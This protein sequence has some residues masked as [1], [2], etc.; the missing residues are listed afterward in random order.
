M[1]AL[2]VVAVV[3]NTAFDFVLDIEGV[4]SVSRIVRS[5]GKPFYNRLSVTPVYDEN[6]ELINY[7][8]VQQKIRISKECELRAERKI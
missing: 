5:D 7:I 4:V 6:G 8:G 1:L 2:H 3:L